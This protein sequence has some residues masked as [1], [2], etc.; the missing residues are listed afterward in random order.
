MYIYT[1]Y[2]CIYVYICIY[3]SVRVCVCVCVCVCVYTEREREGTHLARRIWPTRADCLECKVN[4]FQLLYKTGT[5]RAHVQACV[6]CPDLG[7]K[8]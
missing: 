2:I 8:I 5:T 6:P 1:Y 3:L 7:L 4:A